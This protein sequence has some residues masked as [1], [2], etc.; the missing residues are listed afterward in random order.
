MVIGMFIGKTE[1]IF[2]LLFLWAVAFA[3]LLEVVERRWQWV[4]D[5]P[6]LFV[7]IGDGLILVFVSVLLLRGVTDWWMPWAAFVIG[8]LP[9]YLRSEWH[10]HQRQR[11]TEEHVGR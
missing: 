9:T 5:K 4:S 6:Q 1:L 11:R 3:G 2:G 7:A 10:D 8:G